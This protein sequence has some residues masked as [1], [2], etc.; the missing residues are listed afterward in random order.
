VTITHVSFYIL[1]VIN[2]T[3]SSQ[4]IYYMGSILT[5]SNSQESN[6]TWV[7]S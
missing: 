7:A 6:S 2:V 3:L 1:A 5:H 4:R